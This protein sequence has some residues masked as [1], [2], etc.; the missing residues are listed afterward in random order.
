VKSGAS[1]SGRA[2]PVELEDQKD[3]APNHDTHPAGFAPHA[4][5]VTRWS[6]NLPVAFGSFAMRRN[7]WPLA[8]SGLLTA[9]CGGPMR[10]GIC[11]ALLQMEQPRTK[12]ASGGDITIA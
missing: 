11:S 3:D 6:G 12:F 2:I 1:F 5:L 9:Y 8:D 4:F 7:C 10:I